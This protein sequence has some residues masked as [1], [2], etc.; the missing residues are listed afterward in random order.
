MS[1]SYP[2][3]LLVVVLLTFA[4]FPVI[5]RAEGTFTNP[6]FRELKDASEP[7]Y[8]IPYQKPTVKEITSDLER[9][10]AYLDKA[11]PAR[12]MDS[13]TGLT[14]D[15]ASTPVETAV[16]DRGED[17]AL[18]PLDYTMGVVHSGMLYAA[19]VTGDKRFS[20]FTATRLK[21]ILDSLPYIFRRRQK[22]SEMTKGPLPHRPHSRGS[23]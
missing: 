19:Q 17:N 1:H 14:I 2:R 22:R 23:R 7:M 8:P 11:A 12:I 4:A 5:G 20:D 18:S 6:D 10:L 13:K 21:F 16:I 3:S 9:I 15:P